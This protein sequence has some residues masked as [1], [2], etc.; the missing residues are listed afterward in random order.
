MTFSASFNSMFLGYTAL[1][2]ASLFATTIALT[3]VDTKALSHRLKPVFLTA[4]WQFFCLSL[5]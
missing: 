3:S 4:Q 5:A 2:S 1:F